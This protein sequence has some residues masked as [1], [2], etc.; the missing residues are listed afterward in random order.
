VSKIKSQNSIT[1]VL[2]IIQAV[3]FWKNQINVKPENVPIDL[4]FRAL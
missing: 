4:K 2:K 1:E 3:L